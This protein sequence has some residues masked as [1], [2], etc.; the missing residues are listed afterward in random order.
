[1]AF[2][3][4]LVCPTCKRLAWEN[5]V[6]YEVKKQRWSLDREHSSST[7]LR[8]VCKSCKVGTRYDISN[9]PTVSGQNL[10]WRGSM[11]PTRVPL[12]QGG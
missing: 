2:S 4:P 11:P 12:V 6:D 1:M 9:N 5:G 3:G 10:A 8:Y 7:M